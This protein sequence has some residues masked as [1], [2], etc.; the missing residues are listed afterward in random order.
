MILLLAT[1][2]VFLFSGLSKLLPYSSFEQFSWN[3]L[4]AGISNIQTASVIARLF[5][6]AELLLGVFLLAHVFLRSFT[7]PAVIGLL[8]LFSI[9][10]L[11]LIDR[12]GTEG[13][14]GCF[15]DA[16][17]MNPVMALIKNLMMVVIAIILFRTYPSL[18]Y[19]YQDRIGAIGGIAAMALPFLLLPAGKSRMPETV[20]QQIN[21]EPL[22]DSSHPQNIP[23][24]INLRHGKH[25]VAFLSL[26]CNHCRKAAFGFQVLYRQHQELPLFMIL[27]GPPEML[28]DFFRE[29]HSESVPN[30]YFRGAEEFTRMAG[31]LK[32]PAIYWINN[33]RIEK[34]ATYYQ[35]DPEVMQRWLIIR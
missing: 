30:V 6:G 33:S 35:L 28:A 27:N 5:I 2:A 32:F 21:L 22:Y 19:K 24:D 12:Q 16:L 9:Y 7:L 25:I 26:S 3:L 18:N 23:P 29:T 4:D 8:I 34:K 10:L 11:I 17:P 31:G 15:G 13:N 14:C 1:A 20:S